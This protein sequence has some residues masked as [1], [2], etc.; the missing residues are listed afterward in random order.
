MVLSIF[1]KPHRLAACITA[2]V[3]TNMA[4]AQT[5]VSTAPASSEATAPY[6][7]VFKGY[8]PY[9]DKR[10]VNWKAANDTTASI[11]GW[12]EY[13]KQAQQSE[14]TAAPVTKAG[15]TIPKPITKAKP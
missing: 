7:S 15:E 14:N 13:A 12:R 5:P 11:G 9:T 4:Y 1:I 2:V 10:I 8:N 6:S 3:L